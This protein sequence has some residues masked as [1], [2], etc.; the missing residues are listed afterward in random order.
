[1]GFGRRSCYRSGDTECRGAVK[2]L[3][4]EQHL[5]VI[6]EV[7]FRD[8]AEDVKEEGVYARFKC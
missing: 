3:A 8:V 1:M 2:V 7:E 6:V 4:E 5:E